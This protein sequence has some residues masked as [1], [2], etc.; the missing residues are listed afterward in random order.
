[1]KYGAAH[2]QG[3]YT[4]PGGSGTQFTDGCNAIWDLGLRT[5]KVY[6]TGAYLTNYPL[7]TAWSSTPTTCT[8]L[9]QTT[10]FTTQ[11]SKAWDTV[12]MTVFTFANNP[13]T[14]TNWWRVGCTN[15]KLLAEYTEIYNLAV[16][17]LT[18]YNDSGKTFILQNWE[19]DWAFMD[20]FDPATP[21][22]RKYVDYYAAFAQ[23]R[24]R[25]VEDA[26]RATAHTNVTV[27]NAFE[28]NRVLDVKNMPG[29]RRILSDLAKRFTPDV[30]SWSA[31]DGTISVS[32]WTAS[33]ALWETTNAAYFKQ[34]I[35]LIRTAWPG[36]R[37]SVG[38]F[39]YPENEAPAGFNVSEMIEIT[40]NWAVAAGIEWFIYWEVFD[41]EAG[42]PP[43]TYRG[44]WLI[45]ND[46]TQSL[47][48]A[49]FYA[50]AHA[51]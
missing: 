24:Q 35:A 28:C 48:G 3:L 26:R 51:G 37:I 15:A 22:D 17:L 31:Y 7:Q 39:G 14:V 36:C 9:C 1:M 8:E 21:V 40:R 41:N 38:E 30:A 49:K 46:G 5:L 19:G 11:L 16:H 6:C 47:A 18:T 45:K 34:G 27:L 50:Y 44:Y 32:G 13:G 43:A 4:Y 12:I 33:Q 10:Q 20:A 29:S 2:V 23:Y 25:A 42:T